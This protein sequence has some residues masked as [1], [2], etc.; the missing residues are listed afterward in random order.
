MKHVKWILAVAVLASLVAATTAISGERKKIGVVVPT[1]SNPWWEIYL[2]FCEQGARELGIDLIAVNANNRP[3]NQIKGLE[4]LVA[5][6]V[7]G[8]IFTPYWETGNRGLTIGKDY[9]EIPVAVTDCFPESPPQSARFPNYIFFVGPKD[10]HAGYVMAKHLFANMKPN[11]KGEK[12]VGIVNGPAGATVAEGRRRGFKKA[13][14]ETPGVRLA[15]EA[16][17]EFLRE[18]ALAAFESL[19]QGNPDI[20]G[21]MCANDEMATGAIAVIKG[22][23]KIPGKDVLVSGIDLNDNAVLMVSNGEQLFT[24]GGHWLAGGFALITLYDWLNGYRIPADRA[25]FEL[26][27]LPLTKDKVEQYEREFPGGIPK[28]FEFRKYSKTYNP[29]IDF[30][31][32]ELKYDDR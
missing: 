29:D 3:D 9:G 13:I 20:G 30:I 27:M 23:G 2:K 4:D 10:E 19:Y 1:L 6:G 25:F 32:F 22:A 14:A 31:S 16:N 11:A 24:Q 12:V 18:I 8:I 5:Q 7:D 28:G 21:V 17:G 26:E 15:G